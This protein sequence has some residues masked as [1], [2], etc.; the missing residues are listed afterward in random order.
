MRTSIRA[1]GLQVLS[2]HQFDVDFRHAK[3]VLERE[4]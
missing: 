1:V 3:K 4:F 2:L